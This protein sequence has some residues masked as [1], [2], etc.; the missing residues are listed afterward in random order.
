MPANG[1][2]H[3]GR[4]LPKVFLEVWVFDCV[5]PESKTNHFRLFTR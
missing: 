2:N 4:I 3:S 1:P 5:F